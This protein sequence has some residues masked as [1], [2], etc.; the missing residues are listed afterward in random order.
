MSAPSTPLVMFRTIVGIGML[1]ALT[2]VGVYEATAKRIADNEARALAAAVA[3][4]LPDARELRSIAITPQDEIVDVAAAEQSLPAFLGFGENGELVGAAITAAGMGYQDTIKV[5]YAYSFDA[6]AIVGFH[7]L[8]SLETPGIG[9]KIKEDPFLS[10]FD[11]LDVSLDDTGS[12]LAN[13]IVTVPGGTKEQPWQ[14]DAIT[15]ATVSSEAVAALLD[16]SAGRWVPVL[17]RDAVLLRRRS[18]NE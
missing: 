9:T 10:N 8:Q 5:I 17:A 15:G 18:D 4:V 2:I 6:S 13:P 12:A 7:V 1:C 14:I 3:A 16:E 11:R